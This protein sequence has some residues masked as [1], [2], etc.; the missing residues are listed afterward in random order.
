[1]SVKTVAGFM[2][3]SAESAGGG[4]IVCSSERRQWATDVKFAGNSM[5]IDTSRSQW[6]KAANSSWGREPP[7][8]EEGDAH[9]KKTN[10]SR[11]CPDALG[12]QPFGSGRSEGL[13]KTHGR[14]HADR[15]RVA[16]AVHR[17]GRKNFSKIRLRGLFGIH[18]RLA[19]DQL[20]GPRRRI[21]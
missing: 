11:V 19:A 15:G 16:A 13:S 21:S 3:D 5:R 1:M 6:D 20:R 12:A 8:I 14:L 7:A 10:T 9:G 17:R 2:Q 18:G 4:R